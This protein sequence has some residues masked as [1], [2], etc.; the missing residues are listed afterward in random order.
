MWYIVTKGEPKDLLVNSLESWPDGD[1]TIYKGFGT[2]ASVAVELTRIRTV[3]PKVAAR[4]FWQP[5]N[6]I[7]AIENWGQYSLASLLWTLFE[8]ITEIR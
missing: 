7:E 2:R 4:A 5:D 6:L 3:H 1:E 8:A